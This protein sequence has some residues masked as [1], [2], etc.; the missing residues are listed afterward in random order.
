VRAV[1]RLGE[2]YRGICLATD[3]KVRENL[4]QGSL[5]I[6]MNSVTIK[7]YQVPDGQKNRENTQ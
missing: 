2:L 5:K 1:P 7:S 6:N 3:E 4:S